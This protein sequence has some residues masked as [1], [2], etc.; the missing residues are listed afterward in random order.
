VVTG[1]YLMETYDTKLNGN[2]LNSLTY[3]WQHTHTQ[4]VLY[5]FFLLGLCELDIAYKLINVCHRQQLISAYL[6][7]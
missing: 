5:A 4:D 7:D 2:P 1:Y 6:T 3:E